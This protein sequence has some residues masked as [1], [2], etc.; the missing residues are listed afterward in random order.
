[1]PDVLPLARTNAEA[2]LFVDL[3]PCPGCARGRCAFRSSVVTVGDVLASRYSG[4]C[5]TCGQHREYEFRLPEEILPPPAGSVRF[6]G[7][8][9]SQLLDPG[10]WLWYSDICAQQLPADLTTIG[11][12]ELRGA[13]HRLSTA[14]AAVGEA[15]KFLAPDAESLAPQSFTSD[16]GRAEYQRNPGRFSRARLEAIRD[17]YARSLAALN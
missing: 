16:R 10:E 4:E 9:P 7:D 14:V 2:R 8:D 15:L 3:Q 13:R 1:M 11:D 5:A 12:Q 6:G 17:H